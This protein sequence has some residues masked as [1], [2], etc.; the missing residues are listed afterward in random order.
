MWLEYGIDPNGEM[1]FIES[2]RRGKTDLKCPYCGGALTAKKGAIKNHHFAHTDETCRAVK[3][4][5]DISVPFLAGFDRHLSASEL[6]ALIHFQKTGRLNPDLKDKLYRKDFI[7]Q[8]ANYR[9]KLD[10]LGEIACG[11]MPLDRFSNF[12]SLAIVAKLKKLETRVVEADLKNSI[13]LPDLLTDLKLYKNHVKRILFQT[14]YFLKIVGDSTTIYKIGVTA[15]EISERID[16]IE[17]ELKA[18]L[19]ESFRSGNPT[20]E[21]TQAGDWISIETLGLW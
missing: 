1:I 14:L 7:V 20:V 11:V 6:S 15:R 2:R 19:A 18:A 5:R 17:P 8:N 10:A 13:D 3:S 16:E 21:T 4:S 9:W 12:Q